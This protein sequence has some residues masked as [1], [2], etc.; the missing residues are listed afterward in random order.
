MCDCVVAGRVDGAMSTTPQ[1][2][3]R[4]PAAC[5]PPLVREAGDEPVDEASTAAPTGLDSPTV[6]AEKR[7]VKS[8]LG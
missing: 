7:T 1:E 4:K 3:R 5:P 8:N 6:R 2:A